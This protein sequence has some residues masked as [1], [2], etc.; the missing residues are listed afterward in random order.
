MTT[1]W[2]DIRYGVRMLRRNPG[3]TLVPVLT[4]AFGAEARP[5]ETNS[6]HRG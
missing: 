6:F 4:L 1:L 2:Q 3:F 5:F